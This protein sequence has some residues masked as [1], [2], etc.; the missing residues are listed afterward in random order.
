MS[1]A[2]NGMKICS[3]KNCEH[4]GKP[5]PVNNFDLNKDKKDGYHSNCK[6][7]RRKYRIAN[8]TKIAEADKKYRDSHQE[9]IKKYFETYF[10]TYYDLPAKYDSY[11]SKL[12]KYEE[13]RRDPKNQ[14]LLQVRCKYYKCREWF[15]PTNSVVRSRLY[16]INGKVA[17]ESNFYCSDDC[18]KACPLFGLNHDP[19]ETKCDQKNIRENILQ[20]ELREMVLELD[21]YTC[22]KCNRS[23]KDYPDLKLIC[24]HT[25]PVKIDPS[26]ASD[27]NNC[28][29]LCERCHQEVHKISDC[30]YGFLAKQ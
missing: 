1:L 27:I 3:N 9:H 23:L 16:A 24:H 8:K 28:T 15:N 26:L 10:Q 29:T 30:T 7:C 13:V 4:G 14:E 21:N 2:K 17:G 20:D 19:L 22:Q 12:E 18:K 25:I 5:Q 6:D 11:A